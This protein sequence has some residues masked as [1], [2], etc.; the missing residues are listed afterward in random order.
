MRL[1]TLREGEK[2]RNWTVL[3]GYTGEDFTIE[4]ASGGWGKDTVT[5]CR[6]H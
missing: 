4:S 3:K 5:K 2:I 1:S 6:N